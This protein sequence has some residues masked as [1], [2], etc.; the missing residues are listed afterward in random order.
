MNFNIPKTI[1]QGDRITWNE[2]IPGYKPNTDTLSCFVRGQKGN[3]DLTA[4]AD[5]NSWKFDLSQAITNSFNPG[6]YK[7]Q[8]VIFTGSDRHTLG[9]VDLEV[10]P[11]FEKITE[12]DPRTDDEKELE[13][14]TRAIA[15]V[16][17]GGVAEY[18]IGTRRV[19]YQDLQLLTDR[20]RELRQRIA[21]ASGRIKPGGRN[22]G[23]SFKN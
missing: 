3:A 12:L 6:K 11:S 14:V 15:E 21:I 9:T 19:R 16:I 22:V 4:T 10:L 8:F 18:Y 17:S 7:A 23:V 20:Q 5:G 13:E 1:T 2:Q